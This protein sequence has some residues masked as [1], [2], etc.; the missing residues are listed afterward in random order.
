MP[1]L[2][3][4]LDDY[5]KIVEKIIERF[6]HTIVFNTICSSTEQRQA[7]II[8]LAG[9]MDAIFIVGGKNSA[10]TR[11][12]ADLAQKQQTP[13]FHI[14]T[15]EELDNINIDSYNRIG[16]SA[17]AST[18]NWIIDQVM[19]K[20]AE[21]K[22]RKLKKVGSLFNVWLWAIKTD[23][24][25]AIGRRLPL[26]GLHAAAENTGQAIASGRGLFFCL[27]NAYYKQVNQP[28]TGWF[29]GLIP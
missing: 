21:T 25:S 4:I 28:E 6:P 17:G 2:R 5:N 20:I 29:F 10:N 15:A 9:E 11:R 22:S 8:A 7:E 12:L 3:K 14:E 1:R 18:P 16:V 26:S 24:Y 19:D 23:L 27:C 13:A